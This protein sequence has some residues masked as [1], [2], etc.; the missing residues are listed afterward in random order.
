MSG[1]AGAG[2]S[3][4]RAPFTFTVLRIVQVAII[5]I[6]PLI[7]VALPYLTLGYQNYASE[8]VNVTEPLFP[9]AQLIRTLNVQYVPSLTDV[10][11]DDIQRGVDLLAFGT[12]AHQVALFT[13]I[14]TC[15]GLFM[16]EINK[17]LWWPLHLSGWVMILGTAAVWAGVIW[18]QGRGV[19]VALGPGWLPFTLGGLAILV[20]TFRTR[21]RLD[22]YRG[23]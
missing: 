16:D 12:T 13:A 14:F 3:Y 6:L 8:S 23:A 18:W 7:G 19:D 20:I 10:S 1:S 2:W 4:R 15:W 21:G 22:T 5:V 11:P 9:V 17:F